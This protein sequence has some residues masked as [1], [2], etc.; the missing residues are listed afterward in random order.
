MWRQIARLLNMMFSKDVFLKE[1]SKAV[2]K[3]IPTPNNAEKQESEKHEQDP[4]VTKAVRYA[5]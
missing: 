1:N 5:L 2:Q 4:V 3:M